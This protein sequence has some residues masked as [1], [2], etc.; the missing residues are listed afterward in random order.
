MHTKQLA[1]DWYC[2]KHLG[3]G[4][5]LI[6]EQ[7]VAPWLRCNIWHVRGRD[8]DLIID[9]GL[10]VRPLKIEISRLLDKPVK[11]I[12]THSHFDHAGGAH[13]F[14]CR[15][16]HGA[17]ADLMADPDGDNFESDGS[18]SDGPYYPFVQAETFKALPYEGF[19][20][21]AYRVRPAPLTGRLDEGDVLDLG[22]RVFHVLHLPGHSPGSIALYEKLSG[23]LFSGDVIYDG[24]L[25]DNISHSDPELLRTSL[26]RLRTLPVSV[27]HGGHF[28][29][30]GREKMLEI[31]GEYLGGGRR[32]DNWNEWIDFRIA[33]E[34][35]A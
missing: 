5:S 9:T 32:I 16:G 18:G 14:E 15:L 17:E 7:H 11:A 3:E 1:S 24:D 33:E 8:H 4:V 10:G 19:E 25:I 21:R 6:R 34:K 29:S 27:V 31:I 26:H 35:T 12:L 23:T 22:D 2:I 13:E 28:G 30:F 20:H